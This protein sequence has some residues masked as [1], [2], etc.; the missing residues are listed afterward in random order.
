MYIL[1]ALAVICFLTAC[2]LIYDEIVARA[3]RLILEGRISSI[4]Y[5]EKE[6]KR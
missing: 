5:R 1:I 3:E 6:R 2:Y 4:I